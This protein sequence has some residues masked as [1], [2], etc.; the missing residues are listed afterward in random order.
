VGLVEGLGLAC[1]G[2]VIP[3]LRIGSL[4]ELGYMMG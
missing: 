1:G 4:N 2:G 3:I